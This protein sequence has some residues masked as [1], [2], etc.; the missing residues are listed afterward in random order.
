MDQF[1]TSELYQALD[2]DTRLYSYYIGEP[3]NA[4][5]D[6]L[7]RYG[8][9]TSSKSAAVIRMFEN[10]V[11]EEVF[12]NATR[13]FVKDTSYSNAPSYEFVD[14]LA[15]SANSTA[16]KYFFHNLLPCVNINSLISL[17]CR[18]AVDT[19]VTQIGAPVLSVKKQLNQNYTGYVVIQEQFPA[20]SS[21]QR[22]NYYSKG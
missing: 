8:V 19:Y 12:R 16:L 17:N 3:I 21:N 4:P 18:R 22:A 9:F 1:L 7:E 15:E 5:E 14:M 13:K 10:R 11:G 2:V 6:V 20:N